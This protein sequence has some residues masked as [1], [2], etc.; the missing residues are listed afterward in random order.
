[1]PL[2]PRNKRLLPFLML[3]RPTASRTTYAC[4][5]TKGDQPS[6]TSSSS[7]TNK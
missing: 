5:A 4:A 3:H 6:F 1:M 2:R 7:R